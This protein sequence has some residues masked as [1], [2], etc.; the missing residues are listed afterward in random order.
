MHPATKFGFERAVHE[1]ARWCAVEREARSPAP[2]WWWDPALAAL[3]QAEPMPLEWSQILGLPAAS[4]YATGA[5]VLLGSL[6]AQTVLPWPDDFP[7][8]HAPK[9]ILASSVTNAAS[10]EPET[11]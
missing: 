9:R 7:R 1:F 2:A 4:A 11:Q 8:R 5:Q 3:Q 10:V 6:A